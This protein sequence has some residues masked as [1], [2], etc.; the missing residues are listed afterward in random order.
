MRKLNKKD[1][2]KHKVF[3]TTWHVMHW[4]DL[5]NA[6]IDDWD[7]YLVHNN[8]RSWRGEAFLN[9]RPIP[10]NVTFVPYYEEKKYDFAILNLD[11]Q[12]ANPVLGKTVLMK[13]LEERIQD[14]PKV[15]INH[16]TPVYPEYCQRNEETA[17]DSEK[18]VKRA[19][20]DIVKDN[21]MV[22]NSYRSK[23]RWGND[24]D[25]YP[26][27]HGMNPDEWY[28]LPK[29]PRV[30]TALSPAGCDEYYNRF[31]MEKVASLLQERYGHILWWAKKNIDTH[32]SPEKYKDFLGRSLIYLDV[33]H[34]T[35]MNR[36]RTEAMLSGCCVVQ[37]NG[38]HDLEKF[39][40]PNKNMILIENNASIIVDKVNELLETK[41]D[42]CIQIGQAGK[43]TAIEKFNRD[44]YRQDWLRFINNVLL[45]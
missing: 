12:C 28:D 24:F 25:S 44:R 8:H 41:Y 3:C 9:A 37:V 34:D 43:K 26:I 7:V 15:F 13:E 29:E 2:K 45:A 5:F 11:Q 32:L 35:P 20:K 40:E 30:F 6:M 19:I 18:K 16:A 23:E 33:S 1:G 38:A 39:A 42:M 21:P 27:W 17:E 14:I 22:V 4:W 31:T 10:E 36:A